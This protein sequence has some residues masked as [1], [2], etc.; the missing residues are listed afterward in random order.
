MHLNGSIRRL[1]VVIVELKHDSGR[2]G[3]G[4]GLK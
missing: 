1:V 2:V 3:L 4:G